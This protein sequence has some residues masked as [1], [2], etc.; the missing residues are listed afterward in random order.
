MSTLQHDTKHLDKTPEKDHTQ[1][2]SPDQSTAI[3]QHSMVEWSR[4]QGV[5]RTIAFQ[6]IQRTQGNARAIQLA[7]RLQRDT[8]PPAAANQQQATG[9]WDNPP[10]DLPQASTHT[11]AHMNL[12]RM[13]I[14]LSEVRDEVD[15]KSNLES[16]ISAANKLRSEIPADESP[17]TQDE[18]MKLLIVSGYATNYHDQ[19][20]DALRAAIQQALS[21][22]FEGGGD[23]GEAEVVENQIKE[24]LHFA[25]MQGAS[26]DFITTLK[27]G[28]ESIDKY[29][30]YAAKV[31]EWA[32]KATD[33]VKAVKASEYLEKFGKGSSALGEGISKMKTLL[34]AAK[35]IKGLTTN[36]GGGAQ[37]ND[38]AK[39]EAAIQAIDVAM[40]FAKAVPLL[41]DLW[42]NYYKPLTEA[43]IKH[44]KAIARADDKNMRDLTLVEW[45]THPDKPRSATGAPLLPNNSLISRYFPGG[46]PILDFMWALVNNGSAAANATVE[47]FFIQHKDL[48]NAGQDD[49]LETKSNVDWYNPFTW[50]ND[51]SAANLIPWVTRNARTVWSMLYGSMPT[52]I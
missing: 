15:D 39:F 38:I 48:L 16:T 30:G 50:G 44:L 31:G 17:L 52:T 27:Q 19:A 14:R 9:V 7:H 49:K 23:S 41:G 13:V 3:A 25:F 20:I 29:R 1:L 8:A 33:A 28:L 21:K 22:L 36:Q 10:F 5:Q 43:C 35:A 47:Q 4:L 12:V 6:R 2:D 18:A 32:K 34:D 40:T 42:S 46:Q 26:E 24:E 37:F 51:D 45:M 11:Q